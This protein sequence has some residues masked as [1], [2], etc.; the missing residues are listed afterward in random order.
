MVFIVRLPLPAV[1][2]R[3]SCVYTTRICRFP[4]IDKLAHPCYPASGR[5]VTTSQHTVRCIISVFFSQG[6]CFVHQI[7]VNW[8]SVTQSWSVI[9]PTRTFRLQIETDQIGC[10]KSS[11]RRA[12]RMKTHVIQTIVAANAEHPLPGSYVHRSI[13][14][15]WEITVFHC[16]AKHCFAA[17]DVEPFSFYLEIAHSKLYL[18]DV[19]LFTVGQFCRQFIQCRI[20]LIPCEEIFSHR[21]FHLYRIVSRTD[22]EALLN[23]SY[24]VL[25]V[26]IE[27]FGRKCNISFGGRGRLYVHAYQCFLII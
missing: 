6:N 26:C 22:M 21:K 5:F 11:F 18:F 10:D 27:T 15:Q 23:R 19:G 13:T 20:E 17:I 14:G 3:S 9:R 2:Y 12:E 25:S 8:L 4:I 7:F 24:F 1:S 16:A